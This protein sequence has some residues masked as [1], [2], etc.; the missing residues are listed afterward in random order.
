[1]LWEIFHYVVVFP[2][3]FWRI[4]Y[5][6]KELTKRFFSQ[7]LKL[8]T[9][10]QVEFKLA[11]EALLFKEFL[12]FKILRTGEAF[13]GSL[14]S[15]FHTRDYSKLIDHCKETAVEMIF[16]EHPNVKYCLLPLL[17]TGGKSKVQTS[18]LVS[19]PFWDLQRVGT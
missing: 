12:F 14:K 7:F 10:R 9:V 17:Y 18:S 3:F 11:E 6:F 4:L 13:A 8:L 19:D 2:S 5:A 1:M 15:I 16:Q